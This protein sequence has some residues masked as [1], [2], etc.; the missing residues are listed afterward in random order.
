MRQFWENEVFKTS[1]FADHPVEDILEKVAV[2]FTARHIRGRPRPPYW[3]PGWPLYV[4]DSRYN[5]RERIFVKIKNWNSCVPEE[6]RKS[7]SFMSIYPFERP[8]F[9]RRFASPFVSGKPIKAPGG[10]G[11]TIERPEG[12]KLE[13]GGTGRKRTRRTNTGTT[14]KNELTDRVGQSKGLYVGPLVQGVATPVPAYQYPV[15]QGQYGRS[16]VVPQRPIV[17]RSIL[18]AAGGAA[19]LAQNALTERLPPETGE[20]YQVFC[21]SWIGAEE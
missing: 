8:V 13:G 21:I 2:Q 7:E 5:D 14:G 10:I 16:S 1:H 9:P 18:T 6:V 20:C 3:Y 15:Q 11:D 4:C 19:T 12:E 17:D